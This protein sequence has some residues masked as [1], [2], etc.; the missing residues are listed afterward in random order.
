M[1]TTQSEARPSTA[2]AS[3]TSASSGPRWLTPVVLIALVVALA[4]VPTLRQTLG[5]GAYYV[6]FGYSLFFWITQASA[7]NL[8][9]G[10]SGYLNFGHAIFYG[11]GVYVTANL[12]K[13]TAP[14]VVVLLL[15]GAGA[16]A[17]VALLIGW[18]VFRRGLAHEIFALFTFALAIAFGV[19]VRNIESIGGGGVLMVG[20][21]SYPPALGS[22]NEML[23]YLG[24]LLAVVS[25][26]AAWLVQ[27]S[28]LGMGLAA[29]RDDERVAETIGV[30]TF[31]YKMIA[32]GI[33]AA[34]AGA[35][36]ALNAVMV[37]FIEPEATFGIELSV[38]V[39][40]MA[41][42]GGRRHWAGPVVG[43]TLM[44]AL[45]DR[46]TGLGMTELSQLLTGALLILV[47]VALKGGIY[48]QWRRRPSAGLLVLLVV[49]LGLLLTG[50]GGGFIE[51][52]L[53]GL[54]AMVAVL[55]LPDRWWSAVLKNRKKVTDDAA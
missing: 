49:M 23:Y 28:R 2:A 13:D 10:F 15:L 4:L 45:S 38:M 3:R 41:L 19:L 34:I 8:F 30:P 37:S 48:E 22:I 46:L 51:A 40:L 21:V 36:G 17:L 9:S 54:L 1:T 7:W 24:L 14:H 5:F 33:A 32:L 31:R 6:V 16:A 20:D 29:I 12:A 25:V 26:A 43:A 35:S 39:V 53:W 18:M 55:V 42:V 44:F 47:V 50:V 27:R 11:A 52:L